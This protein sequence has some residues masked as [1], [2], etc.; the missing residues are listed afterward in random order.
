MK[1]IKLFE[2][3]T[4]YIP[5]RPKWIDISIEIIKDRL[6]NISDVDNVDIELI[7]SNEG[8][9][10]E[11]DVAELLK[12]KI[13]KKN[14]SK[15]DESDSDDIRSMIKHLK[16]V[17][18]DVYA[19]DVKAEIKEDDDSESVHSTQVVYYDMKEFSSDEID[20]FVEFIKTENI[21]EVIIFIAGKN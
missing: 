10:I 12:I 3:F 5:V 9:F 19:I 11:V 20:E 6:S 8:D 13:D 2:S 4:N 15:F 17:D 1:H 16:S 18:I 21:G 14:S 7:D